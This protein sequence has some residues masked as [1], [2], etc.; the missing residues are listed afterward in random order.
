MLDQQQDQ[1]VEDF[2]TTE[3]EYSTIVHNVVSMLVFIKAKLG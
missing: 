1:H 3:T 2:E